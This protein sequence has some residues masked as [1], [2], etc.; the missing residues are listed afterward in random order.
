[1]SGVLEILN[2]VGLIAGFLMALLGVKKRKFMQCF[3]GLT[4]AVSFIVKLTHY[5][6]TTFED[7]SMCAALI[8]FTVGAVIHE[9][10][11]RK[12]IHMLPRSNDALPQTDERYC[13]ET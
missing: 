12:R 10:K 4:F 9:G 8:I 2:W 11:E 6:L 13:D 5:A 3:I 1:M 7:I